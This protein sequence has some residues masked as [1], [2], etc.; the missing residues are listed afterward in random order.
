MVIQKSLLL[1]RAGFFLIIFFVDNN[2]HNKK[3][4]FLLFSIKIKTINMSETGFQLNSKKY[5]KINNI[6]GWVVFLIAA[7]TYLS[8]I[9][10]TTSFWDCGEFI[11]SAYKQE[12]GHPP[13]AP[14]FMI[15]A[16]V[17]SLL[18]FG[19][20]TQVAKWI[21]SLS[22]L[23]SAFTI[24]FLF[25]TITYF[26]DKIV[27]KSHE[28]YS[29]NNLIAVMG[30]GAV[31]ALAYTFS[32]TFWFSAV[33]G[34]VY[35]LSSL[36]T[37][38][39][40]WSILKWE[41]VAD[42]PYANRWLIFI[43]YMMGLSIGVHL[44][45]L[46]AI[47]AIVFV[48]YF[49]KYEPNKRGIIMASIIAIVVLGLIMYGVIPGLVKLAA[50]FELVFVNGFGLPFNTGVVVYVMLLSGGI[51]Y[52]LIY[53][54]K[55]KKVLW[56]TVLLMLTVIVIGYSSFTMIV[57]RSIAEPPMN[58]N[59]P[60]NVFS[61]LAY[62]NREQYGDRPL[63]YGQYFNADVIEQ[64][65][66]YTYLPVGDK[67]KKIPKVNP[68]YIYD[69]DYSTILPRMYSHQQNH[70]SGYKNWANIKN[71]EKKPS[72][73]QNLVFLF[74]YQVGFMYLRYFM[75]NFSGRQNDIQGHGDYLKG[76]WISGIPFIDNIRLGNQDD[77]PEYLKNNKARNKYY[78][79]PLLLG[80]LGMFFL[81]QKRPKQFSI[82]FLLFFFTGLA[83]VLYLNQ[84]PFQPRE[85]D[86]AYA[87]S[88]YAFAIWIGL[89]VFAITDW[90]QKYIK[91]SASAIIATVLSL[92]L[93]PSI[94]AKENWNDHD[95]SGRYTARDFASNYLNSCAPNAIIFTYGDN[96]TFPLWYAQEVE[97]IRTDV[98]VVNLS[99]L[100][101]DWYIYQ[102]TKRAYESDPVPFS[103]SRDKY[104]QGERDY[105]PVLERVK[106]YT[107]LSEVIKF[108]SMDDKRAKVQLQDGSWMNYVPAKL[109]QIP[110][111]KKKVLANGTVSVKDTANLLDTINFK[112]NKKYISKSD[113]MV[114]DLLANFN[115]DRPIYFAASIGTD[116]F[117]G[118]QDYFRL[119][120]FAYR[121]V[122]YKTK[123]EDGEI[124]A[125]NTDI[126]YD[127]VMHKFKW[128]RM[129]HEDVLIDH[130]NQRV[131]S[132]MR[133]RSVFA[134]LAEALLK[135]NKKEKAVEVLDKIVELTP[136]KQ[137]PY[138]YTMLPIV[139]L[140]YKAGE[141]DKANKLVSELA[142]IYKHDLNYYL[143][144][145]QPF[146]SAVNYEIQIGMN[147]MQQLTGLTETYHQEDLFDQISTDFDM[148]YQKYIDIMQ[149]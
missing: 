120:G 39:V 33:E 84:T 46:L 15:A 125:V 99:L 89:G 100:G 118:L 119:E 111:D 92:V 4:V 3:N 11:A 34:E 67:Y 50:G 126:L 131:I 115:W 75:W 13:G 5:R 114:L 123:S 44:L 113:M 63:I 77:L 134:R 2:N 17:A 122:P 129:N 27:Q 144:L 30:S 1:Y 104:R 6:T 82:V 83:I 112:L 62:L 101:T 109:L 25:W 32:D 54:S 49:R 55:K 106:K 138:D 7:F 105:L 79:L 74:K 98:R 69:P 61:L 94:M 97:G 12:V 86:Y 29:L 59:Q 116:N 71:T 60:D 14:L 53:T 58:E 96:D 40:F 73:G 23:A 145:N 9:E 108:I 121:L 37:A 18:S 56:N 148:L 57:V 142:R 35:A 10:P 110:V 136:N 132:I 41:R 127:N 43:A 141:T 68:K 128:G 135:E 70:I 38:I 133:F 124:G 45:N 107:P 139:E 103:M 88:F 51:V 65:T 143:G 24:L 117:M 66:Q 130:Y 91:G 102:M 21:N 76:N 149:K 93:V 31:G 48:Y 26:A 80:L 64:E 87:G 28:K 85:R 20:V 42:E 140:Y 146:I 147:V 16:K 90:L 19:D 8:T 95:R 72:F 81:Y 52:G 36:F 22:A 78:M 137:L 47:P